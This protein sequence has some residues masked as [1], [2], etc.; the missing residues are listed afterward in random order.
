MAA[1]SQAYCAEPPNS[2]IDVRGSQNVPRGAT[3]RLPGA[4]GTTQTAPSPT[5]MAQLLGLSG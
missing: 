1:N 5:N 2:P 3:P 4:L